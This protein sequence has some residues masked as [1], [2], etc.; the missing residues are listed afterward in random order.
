M[1]KQAFLVLGAVFGFLLSR[2]GAT[3]YDFY[4]KLFLFED[5]QLLYVIG[6]AV[7]VGIPGVWLLKRFKLKSTDG[8]PLVFKGKP[9]KRGLVGGSLLFGVGWGLAGVCPGTALA[10]VGEGKMAALITILGIVI[11]TWMYGVF[12]DRGSRVAQRERNPDM[13]ALGGATS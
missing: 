10:M 3:T 12:Q 7:A 4:V 2:A 9:Y 6:T 8:E 1:K 5:L 13:G 11:G